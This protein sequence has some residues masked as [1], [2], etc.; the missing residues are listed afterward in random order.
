MGKLT[1]LLAFVLCIPVLAEDLQVSETSAS[2]TQAFDLKVTA[3]DYPP[4]TAAYLPG[5][6]HSFVALQKALS[7]SDWQ[8]EPL[9]LP[10]ARASS[11]LEKQDDWLISIFPPGSMAGV[12]LIALPG[13]RIPFSLF[14]LRQPGDFKWGSLSELAGK[15]VIMTRT[16]GETKN[17]EAYRE[18]GIEPIFVNDIEQGMKMLRNQR[19]D[20]LLTT[21][22]TGRFYAD[23]LGIAEHELQFA[24]TI[25]RW[26]PYTIYL[27]KGHPQAKAIRQVLVP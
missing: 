2:E 17:I 8:A 4:Y 21:L 7:G 10:P 14:R 13:E 15:S 18:A 25:I 23:Q 24:E 22:A 16:P 1:V 26:F 12:E 11:W 3:M 27:N 20:Y 19:G 9:F 5:N 6:G